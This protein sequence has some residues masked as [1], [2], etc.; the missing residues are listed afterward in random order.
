MET[1]K[2]ILAQLGGNKF[3]TMT[4][5]KNLCGDSTSLQFSLPSRFAKD[6][7][8]KIKITLLPCDLYELTFYKMRGCDLKTVC[9]VPGVY[10]D[11]LQE[12]FTRKTGLDCSL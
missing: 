7:I 10:A 8:N 6:G 4:G 5:A 3:L 11:Q 2:T 1:A 9:E 12:I